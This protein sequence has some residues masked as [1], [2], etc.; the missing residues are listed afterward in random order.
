MQ[1]E[2]DDALAQRDAFGASSA[3]CARGS[4]ESSE[5]CVRNRDPQG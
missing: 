4:V 5:S 2:L 3:N 1:A